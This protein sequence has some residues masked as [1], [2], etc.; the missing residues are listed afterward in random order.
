[1]RILILSVLIFWSLLCRAEAQLLLLPQAK[2][3]FERY[4]PSSR[5]HDYATSFGDL[6]GDGVTDFVTF[7]GINGVRFAD[8]STS[9]Y[10]V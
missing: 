9:I 3:A 5:F 4:A 6:N 10:T 2:A 8:L 7:I 1:M